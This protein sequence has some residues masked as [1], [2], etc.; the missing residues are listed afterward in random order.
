M[1]FLVIWGF[2]TG[3]KRI[4]T[5]AAVIAA[6]VIAGVALPSLAQDE[7]TEEELLKRGKRVFVLCRNV[8]LPPLL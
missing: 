2:I 1:R 8:F 7:M 5:A 6:A 4:F 3:V